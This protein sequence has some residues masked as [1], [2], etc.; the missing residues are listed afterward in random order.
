MGALRGAVSEL[1]VPRITE[2]QIR[3]VIRN[4]RVNFD[5]FYEIV[6][7]V[8]RQNKL[9]SRER[10]SSSSTG[11]DP[12]CVCPCVRALQIGDAAKGRPDHP[13]GKK[14]LPPF[15]LLDGEWR[16]QDLF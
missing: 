16:T 11:S 7:A 13:K 12:L 14:G 9:R 5:V 15:D 1:M 3:D 4:Y 6:T 10:M 8:M 2:T